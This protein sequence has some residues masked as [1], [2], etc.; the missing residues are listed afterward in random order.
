MFQ[1]DIGVILE[2]NC[3]DESGV[4]IEGISEAY[5]YIQRGAIILKRKMD[6]DTVEKKLRYKIQKEDLTESTNYTF[7]P[8]V[9]TLDG[10]VLHGSTTQVFVGR[11]LSVDYEGSDG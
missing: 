10:S 1:G 11:P 8:V 5:L 7:Q 9:E 4:P 3:I 2:F 6:I